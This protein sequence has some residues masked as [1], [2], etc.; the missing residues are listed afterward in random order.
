MTSSVDPSTR[1]ARTAIS[2]GAAVAVFGAVLLGYDAPASQAAGGLF[3][4]LFGTS[5]SPDAYYDGHPVRRHRFSHVPRH[6]RLAHQGRRH[7]LQARRR[8]AERRK[9]A[10]HRYAAV[11]EPKHAFDPAV[12][13]IISPARN[14]FVE[15]AGAGRPEPRVETLM[16]APAME[17]K[18]QLQG[19][20]KPCSIASDPSP[21]LR[22]GAIRE[23]PMNAQ[24]IYADPTLRP[25]DTVVT[26]DGVR[27]LRPG[28]RFLFKASDFLSLE[29]AGKTHIANKS[30]L[31]EIERALKTPVG[32]VPT[33]L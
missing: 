16:R 20:P 31:S 33:D 11:G 4:V 32:R 28:S 30:V 21:A 6:I 19:C 1:R 29:Q 8:V 3:E 9:F 5:R 14:P 12:I 17:P 15:V 7:D 10:S 2:L 18:T 26:T 27:I 23:T 25:G 22:L 24:S 13:D